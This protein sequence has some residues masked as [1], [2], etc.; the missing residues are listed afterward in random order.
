[1]FRENIVGG[2][3]NVFS[4]YTEL[5]D[6]VSV[7]RNAKYAANGERFT[8]ITF[9]DFNAL[10]LYAQNQ[11]MPT[12][13][14]IR[15]TKH[16]NNFRRQIMSTGNSIVALQWLTFIDEFSDLLT[17]TDGTRVPL[18]HQYFR[19]EHSVIDWTIDGY[20][21][22]DEVEHF[23]EFLGCY[24]HSCCPECKPGQVDE[25]W[26][27]KKAY[28]RRQGRLI[29][30]HECEWKRQAQLHFQ[31]RSRYWGKIFQRHDE[32]DLISEI[33][34]DGVFGF[35][36]CDVSCPA[37]LEE[38]IKH[39]NFPPIIRRMNI[40]EDLVSPYMK[41]R[42]AAAGRKL[43]Q[44]TVVQT[45]NGQQILLL[46]T[47][48]KFYLKL[49]L[50]V[51]NISRFIQYRAEFCLGEF[52]NSITDGRIRSLEG[53]NPSKTLANAFKTVGNW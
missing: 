8:K 34:R 22:V 45:Y 13:P 46:T 41:E 15:W 9:L 2:L 10:Y 27:L 47:L 50:K 16:G 18:Q 49:G 44:E 53:N 40:T 20:A 38:K 26:E 35:I 11:Q 33:K 28:L 1:M 36:I 37:D 6:E 4:R 7:P 23:F 24:H 17:Q 32:L 14:G 5:R 30:I 42:A 51:S 25:G 48:V 21:K 3:V 52:C 19:G 43:E 12:T 31:K 29:Y 39:L